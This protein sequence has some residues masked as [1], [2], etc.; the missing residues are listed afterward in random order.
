VI[1]CGL[2]KRWEQLVV[3]RLLEGICESAYTAGAAYLIG[4]YYSKREYLTRY[5][6]FFT[7]TIIAGAVN[8]FISSLLA[9]MGGTAGYAAWRW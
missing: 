7:S 3:C 6:F 4:T 2:V 1:G 5:V 8:G 9:K